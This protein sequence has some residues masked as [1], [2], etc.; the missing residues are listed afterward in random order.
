MIIQ[1]ASIEWNVH[2]H[3]TVEIEASQLYASRL[4]GHRLLDIHFTHRN[5]L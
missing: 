2:E 4:P 1:V 3:D 5:T